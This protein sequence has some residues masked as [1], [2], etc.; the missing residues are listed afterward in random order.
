MLGTD[1][2]AKTEVLQYQ[3]LQTITGSL[4]YSPQDFSRAT[5]PL[6]IAMPLGPQPGFVKAFSEPAV[7]GSGDLRST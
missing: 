1:L 2:L 3:T 5:G 4:M 6:V 7:A